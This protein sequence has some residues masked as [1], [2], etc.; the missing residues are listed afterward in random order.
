VVRLNTLEMLIAQWGH[1]KGILPYVVPAAQLEK[2]EEEVAELRQAIEDRDVE[3]VADAIG[4]IFVTL[5]MQTRAW[6]LD[7]ETCVEQAYKTISQRT[8]KMVDGQFVKDS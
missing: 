4:D 3:E 7:M 2:T 5:V 6:G 8:G 1:D